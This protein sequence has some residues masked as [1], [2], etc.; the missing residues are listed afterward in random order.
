MSLFPSNAAM[1][2]LPYRKPAQGR[3][4]W[5][6]DDAL[7]DPDAVRQRCLERSDWAYGYPTT[8]ELWPGMRA[9]DALRSKELGMLE[10]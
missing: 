1:R 8:G 7:P 2:P 10:T 9:D 5:I 3:D 4:Y 6:V